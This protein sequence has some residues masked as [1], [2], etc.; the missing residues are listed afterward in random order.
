MV[1]VNTLELP[2]GKLRKMH[3]SRQAH[4]Q[5]D[6]KLSFS[7]SIFATARLGFHFLS[8]LKKLFTQ[9]Q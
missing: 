8:S 6:E 2:K 9:V 3:F 1:T 4:C 5:K 7:V